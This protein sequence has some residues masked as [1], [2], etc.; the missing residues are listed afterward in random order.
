[1]RVFCFGDGASCGGVF[2]RIEETTGEG[3][4]LGKG[5]CLWPVISFGGHLE[6]ENH[7]LK[8]RNIL[9]SIRL[10]SIFLLYSCSIVKL[11]ELVSRR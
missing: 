1:M 4:R 2:A 5:G 11:S 6:Y 7:V 8:L 3:G 10:I 9:W